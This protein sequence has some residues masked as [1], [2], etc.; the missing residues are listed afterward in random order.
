M[1]KIKRIC[2]LAVAIL[3]MLCT[4]VTS[5]VCAAPD[6]ATTGEA[7]LSAGDEILF[8]VDL[9]APYTLKDITATVLYN[10]LAMELVTYDPGEAMPYI[11]EN[12]EPPMESTQNGNGIE[13][14][15][16]S[17][18]GMDF[19]GGERFLLVKFRV[20][21]T[22]YADITFSFD[23]MVA[24]NGSVLI[25]DGSVLNSNVTWETTVQVLKNGKTSVSD[26]VITPNQTLFT[27]DGTAKKPGVTVKNGDTTLTQGVD[28][29]LSYS[30]NINP[31]TATVT[32]TG[33]GNY[34]DSK[35]AYF[36]IEE[37]KPEKISV[38][39]CSITLDKTVFTYD[40]SAKQ[41]AVTVKYGSATLVK[42]LDFTVA[43]S[44]NVNAGTATVTV[45]GIGSYTGTASKTFVI[46][47][48]D[49]SGFIWG[50]DNWNFN[51]SAPTYFHRTQFK[52]QINDHYLNVLK[53]NLTNSEYYAIFE[54]PYSWLNST[55]G[56]SCYGMSSLTL[57]AKHGY[58][59]YSD[60]QA[61]ATKLNDFASP[62]NSEEIS[63]LITYYQM[64]QIKDVIQQQYRTVPYRS[65]ETN[66]KDIISTLDKYT[67]C[68]VCFEKDGWG[69]HAILAYGYE[70]G[71]WTFDGVTYDGCIIVCDPNHSV[72]YSKEA[73]IYFNSKTYNW[74][75]PFYSYASVSSANGA[76]FMYVGADI[77]EINQGG[78][79]SGSE[80]SAVE[81][82]VARI[83]AAA[84][85]DN[86]TVSKVLGT[87]GVYMA[88]AS[89]PGEIVEDYSYIV[90]GEAKGTA[91]YNIYDANAAYKVTQE[92]PVELSLSMDYDNCYLTGSSKA[93]TSV[94]FDKTGYVEVTGESADF[95]MSMTFD[96]DYPTS[97]F[98]VSVEGTAASKASLKMANDGYVL[99][100]DNLDDI[101]VN[102]CNKD[103][104]ATASFSATGNS[105][106]IYEINETTVGVKADT[107]NNGTFETEV[108]TYT[109]NALLGDVNMDSKLNIRDATAIQKHLASIA[110]LDAKALAVADFNKD[111]KI[112]IKDATAI[113]KKLAGL[114]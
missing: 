112:N 74:A 75:I 13:Y 15:V 78:Y 9:T 22:T 7:M 33:M 44:N 23:N 77:D 45:T 26:C 91:G 106:Y 62:V 89:A 50:T 35:S 102:T 4:I 21:R 114:I 103:V 16:Y 105:V 36:T 69:A 56:G 70:Y 58:L 60:Y 43:Y 48:S 19:T 90:G 80:Y 34:T 49:I 2:L 17:D 107:D 55:W 104:S 47:N 86:R 39:Q 32:V 57:L 110:T 88:Q 83:D 73:N 68:I 53:Q 1:K 27:Y 11:N 8:Y 42:G 96:D 111:G 40:G 66:I 52:N 76:N 79:L 6:M 5:A 29:T 20:S 3:L 98:T 38:S 41:P 100:S 109:T 95:S 64:L 63:S 87:N 81:N 99:T 113:Q 108:E 85:A 10:T 12:Y 93:G 92:S 82:Y 84:I 72:S 30:N 94:L 71:S 28:Y 46:K 65:H 101:T 67:K 59:P 18:K 97:W 61:S 51:N 24:S 25:A 37:A 54:G 14:K 31:G